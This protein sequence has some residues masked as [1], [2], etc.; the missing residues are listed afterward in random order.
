M[1]RPKKIVEETQEMTIKTDLSESYVVKGEPTT[2]TS[3]R[4]VKL[5][6]SIPGTTTQT[7]INPAYSLDYDSAKQVLY[8]QKKGNDDIYVIHSS[9]V[10]Y[11]K[12]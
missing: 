4:Q 9:N 2:I 7:R 11:I 8:V 5:A 12:L 6:V 3:V 1:S 10:A